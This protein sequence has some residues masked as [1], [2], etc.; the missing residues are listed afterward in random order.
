MKA[1]VDQDICIGCGMCSGIE[2]DAFLMNSDGKA[3][4]YAEGNDD[5]NAMF[6]FSDISVKPQRMS[7]EEIIAA[8]EAEAFQ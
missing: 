5:A 8:A 6:D 4:C 2:P 3:E 7:R 1:Y